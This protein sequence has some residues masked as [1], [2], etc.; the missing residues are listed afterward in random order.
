MEEDM[1]GLL[2]IDGH[3]ETNTKSRGAWVPR[4]GR[5]AAE[6]PWN[7]VTLVEDSEWMRDHVRVSRLDG[8]GFTLAREDLAPGESLS[9]AFER[10]VAWLGGLT[11][12]PLVP[13][14]YNYS[15]I[16]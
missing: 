14:A 1:A 8:E 7:G 11:G 16:L 10:G 3:T 2:G 6:M 5:S 9:T 13:G 12:E 15:G 4:K